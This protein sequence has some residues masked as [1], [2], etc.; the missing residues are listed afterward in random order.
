MLIPSLMSCSMPGMPS[1]VAETLTKRFSRPTVFQSRL[2]SIA[3]CVSWE[4]VKNGRPPFDVSG[5][6]AKYMNLHLRYPVRGE[7]VEP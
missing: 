4:G 5:R 3:P 2:A 6:T 1:G 7:L